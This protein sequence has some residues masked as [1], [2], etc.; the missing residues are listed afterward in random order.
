[1][2]HVK[3]LD[4]NI[5]TSLVEYGLAWVEIEDGIEFIV[6]S[7][8]DND[9]NYIEFFIQ[10]MTED[11]YSG[12]WEYAEIKQI[13]EYAGKTIEEMKEFTPSNV[14]TAVSYL[15]IENVFYVPI[16]AKQYCTLE[17]I[18]KEYEIAD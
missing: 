8:T 9:Y 3:G 2:I 15:G 4:A 13:A 11:D 5:E 6:G 12:L 18:K 10:T 14:Y 17:E 7:N 1:M 16:S